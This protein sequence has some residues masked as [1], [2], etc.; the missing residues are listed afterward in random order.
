MKPSCSLRKLFAA[1]ALVAVTLFAPLAS[2]GQT[3][4]GAVHRGT[5]EG[6]SLVW[7]SQFHL[8]HAQSTVRLASA[9]P[10]GSRVEKNDELVVIEE[11]GQI[12]GFSAIDPEA[13]SIA[14]VIR[15]PFPRSNDHVRLTPPLAGGDA[16]QIVDV[17]GPGGLHFEPLATSPLERRVGYYAY[18]GFAK[19]ARAERDASLAYRKRQAGDLPLY[20]RATPELLSGIDGTLSTEA[21]RTRTGAIG[22]GV[23]FAGMIAALGVAYRR[24]ADAAR[25][26]QAERTLEEEFARI[27]T[28]S[29]RPCA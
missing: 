15:E 19:H 1:F 6:E 22:A 7:R 4:G 8:E 14:V 20:V 9:L 23:I 2:A 3:V 18:P 26:E 25:F 16:L 13:P 21:M 17:S 5:I 12:M 24:F 27:E 29:S 11:K 28:R 10:I